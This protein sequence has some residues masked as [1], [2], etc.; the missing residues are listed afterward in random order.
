MVDVPDKNAPFRAAIDSTVALTLARFGMP[1]I[2][3]ILGYFFSTMLSDLKTG[4]REGMAELKSG[5]QQVWSQMSK[6]ADVQA[7]TN[8]VQSGLVVKIDGGLKQ[9]DRIQSQVDSLQRH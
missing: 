4:Q 5:Q 1:T 8:S 7:A 2:L 9:I 3:A 6:I